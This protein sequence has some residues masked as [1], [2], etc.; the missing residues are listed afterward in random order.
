MDVERGRSPRGAPDQKRS[1]RTTLI[2]GGLVV[3]AIMT[4]VAVGATGLLASGSEPTVDDEDAASAFTVVG[5]TGTAGADDELT[6]FW[7]LLFLVQG[8]QPVDLAD[9]TVEVSLNG[10]TTTLSYTDLTDPS[11]GSEF[12][13]GTPEDVNRTTITNDDPRGVVS[14][15]LDDEMGALAAQDRMEVVIIGADGVETRIEVESPRTV[16]AGETVRLGEG[17]DPRGSSP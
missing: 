17:A 14:F 15:A 16:D 5:A 13:G 3:A 11:P 10:G 7:L 9:A 12:A 6:E 4:I 2:A 8:S 1:G